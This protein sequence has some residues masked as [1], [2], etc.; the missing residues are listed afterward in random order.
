MADTPDAGGNYKK[1]LTQTRCRHICAS[2]CQCG[3]CMWIS[4]RSI[5]RG[6]LAGAGGCGPCSHQ[7][8]EHKSKGMRGRRSRGNCGCG[9]TS[10][11]CFILLRGGSAL[12]LAA[13]GFP[14]S[15]SRSIFYNTRH[16]NKAGFGIV[17]LFTSFTF[18]VFSV[19][20]V[21]KVEKF[22]LSEVLFQRR[23]DVFEL[24]S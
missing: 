7:I 1:S 2:P 18:S 24:G 6:G 17:F 4:L 15:V 8:K 11:T 22:E 16:K 9:Y 13:L 20:V 21:K 12:V 5:I 23:A 14:P 19:G 10:L 3:H